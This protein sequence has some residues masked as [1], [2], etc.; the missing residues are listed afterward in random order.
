MKKSKNLLYE[1]MVI[2][3]PLLPDEIRKVVHESIVNLCKELGG[4][5]RDVDVWGKR[6]LAYKIKSHEE[7]YYLV[8]MLSLPPESLG[9]LKKRMDLK[10]E[11]L[12]Y[13]LVRADES[14]LHKK[15]I[16]KKDMEVNI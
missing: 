16:K 8:Y 10:Q 9:E 15:N 13:L 12:R 4:E 6:Y 3:K 11:A 1:M 7:G 14:E 2:V 5:V